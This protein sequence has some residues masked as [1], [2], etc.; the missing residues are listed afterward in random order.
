MPRIDRHRLATLT[1]GILAAAGME[2][3]KAGITAEILIEGDMIGHETHGV[4]LVPWYVAALRDGSLRGQGEHEVLSDRGTTFV[5]DGKLLP[6]AWLVRQ[7]L[8]LACVRAKE[9]G[10]V[11][12]AIRNA[13]HTCALSSYL[14]RVAEHGMIAQIH[15]S[16]P[17]ASRMAPY[18]GTVPLL[19]PNPI[20]AG[21]PTSGDPVMIDVS[22]SIT[23]TTMTQTLAARGE[24]YPGFWA[25][26][27]T[28][29]PTDDPGEVTAHGGSIMPLGGLEKGHK[30]YG[31]ALM[32][33]LMG[34]GLAGRGR[35]DVPKG[36]FAQSVFLQVLDP[37]A[38][39]GGDAFLEQADFLAQACRSNPPA[40]WASGNVRL[41]GDSAASHRRRALAEG[42][43]V[44][45]AVLAQLHVLAQELGVS[46]AETA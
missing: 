43:H 31:L 35:A 17:G 20:A 15:V 45:D 2:A 25:L 41:P 42:V 27:A 46:P 32:V 29:E 36:T 38:F 28:G 34:Q 13:H 8:D 37:E 21:F 10:V 18:G 7:A 1:E 6:G 9:Y 14:R 33:E 22:C 5:W 24:R 11:T 3:E 12:A 16:N 39:S 4:A 40:G 19:T 23:T 30:G 44:S 26:T